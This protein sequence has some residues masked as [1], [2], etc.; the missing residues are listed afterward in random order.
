MFGSLSERLSKALNSM[1]GKAKLSP[2]NIKDTLNEVR[3]ALLEADVALEVVNTFIGQV[4]S[5]AIGLEVGKKLTPGQFFLKLV[6]EELT[7]LMGEQNAELNL[8]A[9]APVVIL[10]TGLQGSGKTTTV[11]KLAKRL[12]EQQKKKVMVASCDIYRPAAIAQLEL[13]AQEVN[14]AFFPSKVND[15]PVAIAKAAL[16]AAKRGHKDV[17]IL[18]TAGRLHI[19]EHMMQE[20]K[21]LH[22]VL[23]PIETLFVV[24]S[25]TGQDAANTAKAFNVVLPLTGV[26]LTK[27]DGDARGGAALSIRYLTGKPIKF[28]GVGEKLDALEPFYP[29]RIASRILGMGDMLSLIEEI[30]SKV[31]KEKAQ[32]LTDKFVKG[33]KFNLEDFRDQLLQ[34]NKM[35]GL[36]GMMGKL[37]GLGAMSQVAKDK[38]LKGQEIKVFIAII[39]SMTLKERRFPALIRGSRKQRIVEGSG[40]HMREVNMLLRQHEKMQKMMKKLG[41]GAGLMKKM[42][43]LQERMPN[44]GF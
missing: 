8:K 39:D 1:L 18:D 22:Q 26:I 17:L 31:D 25:M 4:Q 24:D 33:E 20:I 34:I 40:R 3:D 41:G 9:Q 13:V 19:D 14:A 29:D 35:G 32:K 23:K 37:P 43:E 42:Q 2:E 6:K 7:K 10:M 5:K 21:S 11:A 38:I 16:D 12:Q 15:D 28:L 44:G 27:I 30:E 36:A